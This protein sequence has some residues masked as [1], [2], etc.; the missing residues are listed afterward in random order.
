MLTEAG[1]LLYHWL[2]LLK[3]S[4]TA[5]WVFSTTMGIIPNRLGIAIGPVDFA[6]VSQFKRGFVIGE[7]CR[8]A[9]MGSFRRPGVLA[10]GL[11]M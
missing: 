3:S 9:I 11:V 1:L 2:R 5:S 4:V 8:S 7:V 10:F 6:H